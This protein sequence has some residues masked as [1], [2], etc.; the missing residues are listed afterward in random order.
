ML[1]SNELVFTLGGSYD[2]ANFGENRSSNATVRV[3]TDGH[4]DA[5][6]PRCME[7]R[8][9]LAMKILSVCLS[10]CQTRGL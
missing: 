3:R 10:V 7:C 1:T 6:L 2:C 5:V 4:T 9:D 8:H